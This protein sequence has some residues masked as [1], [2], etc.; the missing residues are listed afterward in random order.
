MATIIRRAY[1]FL[2]FHASGK[3]KQGR[4]EL[5]KNFSAY[6]KMYKRV[7]KSP[8]HSPQ[9]NRDNTFTGCNVHL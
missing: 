6:F 3:A 2:T 4:R 8:P 1:D 9:D 7:F 5:R